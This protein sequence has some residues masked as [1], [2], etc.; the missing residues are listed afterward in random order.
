M[1]IDSWWSRTIWQ[2]IFLFIIFMNAQHATIV[3]YATPSPPPFFSLPFLQQ[4]NIIPALRKVSHSKTFIPSL[5]HSS[6]YLIPVIAGFLFC[7]PRTGIW[8]HK[9][10]RYWYWIA[11]IYADSKR[12]GFGN[13]RPAEGLTIASG[14]NWRGNSS[15]T[16]RRKPRI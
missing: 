8:R 13:S 9:T 11:L 10:I 3:P 1:H 12:I 6:P 16:A 14:G 4:N 2:A 5:S 7:G 15:S